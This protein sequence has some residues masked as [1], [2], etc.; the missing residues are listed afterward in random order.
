MDT[1][2]ALNRTFRDCDDARNAAMQVEW[3]QG[4]LSAPAVTY[5]NGRDSHEVAGE[6]LEQFE[7][8]LIDHTLYHA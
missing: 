6:V 1:F 5:Q 8:A 3:A 2:T 4:V 7:D